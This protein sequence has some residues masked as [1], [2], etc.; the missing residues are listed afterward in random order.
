MS[1]RTTPIYY[2][3]IQLA[4]AEILTLY[5]GWCCRKSKNKY[6]LHMPI[7]FGLNSSQ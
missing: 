7:N 5:S 2:G 6:V 4:C 3:E 1:D